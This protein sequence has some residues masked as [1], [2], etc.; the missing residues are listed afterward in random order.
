M[1]ESEISLLNGRVTKRS[2]L[3]VTGAPPPGAPELKRLMLRQGELAHFWNGAEP[4]RYIAYLELRPDTV[5]GNH[6][7]LRKRELVYV[8]T[9]EITVLVEDATSRNRETLLL[10]TGDLGFIDTRIAHR[11]QITSP[12]H[13]IE[14]SSAT[15]DPTDLYP[16]AFE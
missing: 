12:G 11:Y 5:R 2:L 9:G 1:S 10:R 6:Y 3:S 7:H 15:F 13:A 8:I 16:W 14:F 4:I